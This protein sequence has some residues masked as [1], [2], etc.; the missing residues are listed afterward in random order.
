MPPQTPWSRFCPGEEHSP[1]TEAMCG[2]RRRRHYFKCSGCQFNDD[3][4]R[5][6]PSAGIPGYAASTDSP[7]PVFSGTRIIGVFPD[8][9]DEAWGWRIGYAASQ[10]LRAMLRGVDRC[11]W[12]TLP[13]VLARDARPESEALVGAVAAGVHGA[14]LDVIDLGVADVGLVHF[15][16]RRLTC[17]G[18]MM[19]S[20]GH[21]P[22]TMTG[23]RIWGPGGRPVASDTGLAE[24]AR[25]TEHLPRR[26]SAASQRPP[27]P[28]LADSW[29]DSLASGYS[30]A[31]RL[32]VVID[33]LH[34]SAGPI[35]AALV[36]RL[37]GV[38]ARLLRCEPTGAF[39]TDPNP[40]APRAQHLAAATIQRTRADVGF[41]VDGDGTRVA[42]LDPDGNPVGP[43]QI[44]ALVAPIVLRDA[45]R[46]T[47]V[48]D[49][50]LGAE[51]RAAIESAGGLPRRVPPGPSLFRRTMHD[52]RAALGLDVW[53][54]YCFEATSY[55]ES[56]VCLVALL[57]R[58]LASHASARLAGSR[59]RA[60]RQRLTLPAPPDA[61]GWRPIVE[62]LRGADPDATSTLRDAT[63]TLCDATT[64]GD[65]PGVAT[66]AVHAAGKD[67][68]VRARAVPVQP[69]IE[70]CIEADSEPRVA[71]LAARIR[72]AV[73]VGLPS[74]GDRRTPVGGGW[75]PPARSPIHP[76]A[77]PR[78]GVAASGLNA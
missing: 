42:V 66:G 53:G 65:A 11:R 29:I 73:E 75:E 19:V 57:L 45:R 9:L 4:L 18:S 69:L 47:V 38:E 33:A 48:Y 10:L 76:S 16:Q 25:L 78:A 31:R 54:N 71:E 27:S 72:A 70:V 13:V 74:E 5:R 14:G 6:A 64:A 49:A 68:S 60:A 28:A 62:A 23:V 46:R 59:A 1:I 20:G 8:A 63:G 77:A 7:A 44:V 58:A 32:R 50:R 55:A 22:P 37:P 67:W 3:E 15:A 30:P 61:L 39:T 36:D 56:A 52:A 41:V 43:A 26:G 51:V 12:R 21:F 24:I 17:C 40:L 2:A 34:G 35:L